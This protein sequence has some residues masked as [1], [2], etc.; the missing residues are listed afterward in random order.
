MLFKFL[1]GKEID[2]LQAGLILSQFGGLLMIFMAFYDGDEMDRA[3]F[4][5]FAGIGIL[6]MLIPILMGNFLNGIILK[7]AF[8]IVAILSALKLLETFAAIANEGLG[9]IWYF[10]VTGLVEVAVLIHLL[11]T[12]GR[13]GLNSQ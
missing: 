2:N 3:D 10:I 13:A 11:S 6:R 1:T 5:V 4:Y 12:K 7:I 8:W 9:F